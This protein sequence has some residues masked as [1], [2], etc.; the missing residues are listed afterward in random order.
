MSGAVE[1]ASENECR[2]TTPERA[3]AR[4]EDVAVDGRV[5]GADGGASVRVSVEGLTKGGDR[6]S[7]AGGGADGAVGV[8]CPMMRTPM[9]WARVAGI[10]RSLL[11]MCGN[12]SYEK[13]ASAALSAAPRPVWSVSANR[14]RFPPR[15]NST[16]MLR[17]PI[18]P[19]WSRRVRVADVCRPLF[20]P[21]V[22]AHA[23]SM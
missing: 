10:L 9:W 13:S 22:A 16:L 17:P 3:A 6:A 15:S 8:G 18:V 2:R 20:T 23:F 14:M 21:H 5:I 11:L 7:G 4:E 19:Y 12:A 1:R